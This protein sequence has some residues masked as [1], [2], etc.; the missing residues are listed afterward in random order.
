MWH[1]GVV[2]NEEAHDPHDL[3][4]LAIILPPPRRDCLVRALGSGGPA[5]NK[6]DVEPHPKLTRFKLSGFN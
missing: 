6:D 3:I 1:L 4:S 5:G 2:E